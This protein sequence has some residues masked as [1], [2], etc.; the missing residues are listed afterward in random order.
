MRYIAIN[1]IVTD[2]SFPS[3]KSA[4]KLWTAWPLPKRDA[5]PNPPKRNAFCDNCDQF[6]GA[7]LLRTPFFEAFPIRPDNCNLCPL[8]NFVDTGTPIHCLEPNMKSLPLPRATNLAWTLG[9]TVAFTFVTSL[10]ASLLAQTNGSGT[11]FP[12]L[13]GPALE[14]PASSNGSAT[15]SQTAPQLFDSL[16]NLVDGVSPQTFEQTTIET[17]PEPAGPQLPTKSYAEQPYP[18]P[19]T[20]EQ[21]TPEYVTPGNIDPRDRLPQPPAIVERARPLRPGE[22]HYANPNAFPPSGLTGQRGYSRA[23]IERALYRLAL[24]EQLLRQQLQREAAVRYYNSAR[25]PNTARYPG[26]STCGGNRPSTNYYRGHNGYGR[27]SGY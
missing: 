10:G 6:V 23:D 25:Y 20:G 24:M 13:Q 27:P 22:E 15:R 9:L 19:L 2:R 1:N 14:G 17:I 21:L 11:R 18:E 8:L 4:K 7:N 3:S 26:R 5:N 16:G 12:Q